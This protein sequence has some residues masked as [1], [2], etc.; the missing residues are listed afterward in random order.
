MADQPQ[1]SA[2]Q[3]DDDRARRYVR[4]LSQMRSARSVHE[5][6]WR[7]CCMYSDP[8]KAEDFLAGSWPTAATALTKQAKLHDST[9]GDSAQSL[10]SSIVGGLTPASS[11]WLEYAVDGM[12]DE[13]RRFLE[14]AAEVVWANIHAANYDAVAPEC[15]RDAVDVGWFVMFVDEDRERGGYHFEQWPVGECF[16]ASSQ[17][18]GTVD[19][20]LREYSRTAE[21]VV[22]EF[23]QAASARTRELAAT[24]PDSPVKLLRVIEP[25]RMHVVGGRLAK[26]LPFASVT[27][28]VESKGILRESG[29]H[30]FPCVVP[31]WKLVKSTPYATGPV[32][33]ALP[34]ARE[35][36]ELKRLFKTAGEWDLAPPMVATDDGV[37][38]A[39]TL[40]IGARKLIVAASVENIKQLP[41]SGNWQLGVEMIQDLKQAI[42]K[43]MMVSYL[44]PR[45]G[46]VP[47]ATQVHV[48]VGLLR[49]LLG[50]VYGRMMAEWIKPMAERCFALAL[51]AG[52]LGIPPQSLVNRT[53]QVAYKSPLARAQKLEDVSAIERLMGDVQVVAQV[54]P[55]VLDLIDGDEAVRVLSDGLGVPT[56]VIRDQRALKL[57]REEKA[58]DAQ[59]Q[60][61]QQ[62]AAGAQAAMTDAMA[63]RVAKAA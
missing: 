13:E 24:K 7:E 61:Q 58:R 32:L 15:A 63:Q 41:A 39:K 57:L 17:P 3:S 10:S 22:E 6:T 36:N 27:I 55:E 35:L 28:E 1:S 21:Q 53:L 25:R 45:D 12:T 34:D 51:R 8:I 60:A 59:A 2:A 56:K 49:Q 18:G 47:T 11:L 23:G 42:R 14:N 46:P 52:A 16:I 54:K 48:E 44:E 20:I 19:T 38:N 40:T 43:T 5:P 29:F 31:R 26:N 33:T 9:L 30:E 37:I 4:R 50:P 62:Q